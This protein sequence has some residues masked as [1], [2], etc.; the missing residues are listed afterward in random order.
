MYVYILSINMITV[1]FLQ[2]VIQNVNLYQRAKARF[3]YIKGVSG[4]QRWSSS[5]IQQ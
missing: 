2:L 1:S 5:S 4:E 3:T